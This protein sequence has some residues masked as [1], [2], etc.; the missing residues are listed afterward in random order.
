[1][2][3]WEKGHIDLALELEMVGKIQDFCG[4]VRMRKNRNVNES[5]IGLA[6]VG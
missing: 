1:V 2:L 6:E 4:L 5:E 3:A